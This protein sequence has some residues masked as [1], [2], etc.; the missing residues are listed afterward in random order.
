[1]GQGVFG[2]ELTSNGKGV[3][4]LFNS[5]EDFEEFFEAFLEALELC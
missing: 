4:H 3:D 5:E 2:T 1:M